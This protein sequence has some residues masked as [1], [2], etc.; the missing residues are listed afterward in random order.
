MLSKI[1]DTFKANGISYW[2]DEEGIYSGDEF[3]SVITNAIRN[4][5]IFLFISSVNSNQSKWTSNEIS[6]ALEFKKPI[7]PFRID[8]SPYND[9]VMMKII[10]FDYIE[11]KDEEKAMSKLLR[12]VKHHVQFIPGL[13]Q[14]HWRNIETPKDAHGTVVLFNVGDKW[15]EHVFTNNNH[16]SVGRFLR[17]HHS[18]GQWRI[19]KCKL[20]AG[21][22]VGLVQKNNC[23]NFAV[24][25]NLSISEWLIPYSEDLVEIGT[26]G[27]LLVVAD[28]E[29]N[30]GEDASAIACQTVQDSFVSSTLNRISKDPKAIQRFMIGVLKI[31]DRKIYSRCQTDESVK[32]VCTSV[33]VAY[34]LGIKLYV[35][36]CGNCRCYVSNRYNELIQV[37]KDHTVLQDLV[38]KGEIPPNEVYN[39]PMSNVI[40]RFLGGNDKCAQ[41]ECHIYELHDDDTILLCS[42]GLYNLVEEEEIHYILKNYHNNVH[43]CKN[44]LIE[45]ALNNG[46]IDNITVALMTVKM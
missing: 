34:V 22:N 38:D 14:P 2:F 42:D 40:T 36:W 37:S 20:F 6:T 43:E 33:V 17:E 46:G 32:G 29:N 18:D 13:K 27:A 35:C 39:Y 23:D 24:C 10:S 25:S 21:T 9:S 19:T 8:N 45:T 5:R 3:A 4:S 41:P 26:C 7:I 16:E 1:K 11:C 31:I 15:E 28:G 44:K 12:A 30:A